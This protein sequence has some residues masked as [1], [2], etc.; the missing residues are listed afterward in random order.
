MTR[1]LR[2]LASLVLALA[3]LA[4]AAFA[5]DG[6]EAPPPGGEWLPLASGTR[7]VYREKAGWFG[8]RTIVHEA[9]GWAEVR[10]LEHP[11][12][13]VEERGDRPIFGMD[14][15]GLLGFAREDGWLLRYS[16]LGEDASGALRLFGEEGVRVLPAAP[17][18]GQ[19][20]TQNAHLFRVPGA[21]RAVRH[22]TGE[23]RRVKRLRVPAGRFEDLLRVTM[24]YRDPTLSERPQITFD[25]WYARGVGLVK[26]VTV[27]HEAGG[28]NRLV[29]E[30]E[31]YEPPSSRDPRSSGEPERYQPPIRGG[32]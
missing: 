4:G 1:T 12:W 23:I 13:V 30:L 18:P 3:A 9:R 17:E 11:V 16:A 19:R 29:R 24:Q 26:S 8:R 10:G 7:W 32:Q 20:W 25:D 5:T 28:W 21:A 14:D 6:R 27:N 31:R 22:W 2:G 15:S